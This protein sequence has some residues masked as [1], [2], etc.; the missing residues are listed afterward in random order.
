M[1]TATYCVS[2]V[3]PLG[4]RAADVIFPSLRAF[5]STA[6][7]LHMRL[8]H[9]SHF[10]ALLA[11][12]AVIV[13]ASCSS[14][15][16]P[17]EVQRHLTP[18]GGNAT[19]WDGSQ[20]GGNPNVFFLPPL[21][22]NPNGVAPT[23]GMNPFQPALPVQFEIACLVPASGGSCTG[24]GLPRTNASL[25]QSNQQ[26]Q[27][28]W[29]TKAPGFDPGYVFRIKVW[30]GS[31]NVAFAD[32][33]LISN[34]NPKNRNTSDDIPLPDGRTMPIKVHVQTGWACQNQASC[35]TQVVGNTPPAGQSF[36][37]VI[38][39][40]GEDL[41]AFPANWFDP[42]AVG[43]NQVLVTIEDVTPNFT[44]S[45]NCSNLGGSTQLTSMLSRNHCVRVTTDPEVQQVTN[46]VLIA[47]CVDNPGDLRQE[48]LKYDLNEQ[49]IFLRN[50][51]VSAQTGFICP[52][53][54]VGMS[55]SRNRLVRFASNT[56]TRVG[57]AL[58]TL[59]GPKTAYAIDQGVGGSLDL[60][61]GFSV[62]NL[63]FGAT[64]SIASGNNQTGTVG[65]TLA[66]PMV[67]AVSSLHTSPTDQSAA[68]VGQKLTCTITGAA[69]F[70]ANSVVTSA[71]ATDNLDGTYSC[72]SVTLGNTTGTIFVAVTSASLDPSVQIEVVPTPD[73]Q[74]TSC[75]NIEEGPSSGAGLPTDCRRYPGT[76]T[77]TATATGQVIGLLRQNASVW[78]LASLGTERLP[79]LAERRHGG[80]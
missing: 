38:T 1:A 50:V 70:S 64:M 79:R 56:L 48:V 41:A 63:G 35:V 80:I 15:R 44:N 20:V 23:Y 7:T 45:G 71:A 36:T 62:F 73:D 25:D 31:T 57:G 65:S 37:Q 3:H 47:T 32:V 52:E 75:F 8:H 78:Q 18:P 30:I 34:A 26:Y 58:R 9:R 54:H 59:F 12:V 29:D 24:R 43:A 33:V 19:L 51:N 76:V 46:N 68:V 77:F 14:D 49:P 72:P 67:V 4:A 42:S 39:N 55:Y 28:N 5:H 13:S 69:S 61:G 16:T 10:P 27:L 66:A 60:G 22:A 74:S 6:R 53:N 11:S 40:D 21:V 17:T 2:F